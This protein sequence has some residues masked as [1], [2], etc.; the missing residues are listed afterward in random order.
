VGDPQVAVPSG[1]FRLWIRRELAL[2]FEK[3][4]EVN[5][6]QNE[7]LVYERV[8]GHADVDDTE[9]SAAAI[10]FTGR[11]VVSFGVGRQP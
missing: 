11:V 8:E 9:Q 3:L 10:L 6:G 7:K 4:L 2:S 1:L 5:K